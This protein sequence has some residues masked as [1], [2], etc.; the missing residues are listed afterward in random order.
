[1]GQGVGTSLHPWMLQA[2]SWPSQCIW[3]A[4]VLHSL[5]S[6]I[7]QNLSL[8]EQPD[9]SHSYLGDLKTRPFSLLVSIFFP[10]VLFYFIILE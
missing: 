10:Q 5:S 7:A 8:S 6:L 4:W 9:L 1:M 2:H 3:V